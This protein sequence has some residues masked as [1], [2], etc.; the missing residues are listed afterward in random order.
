MYATPLST[1]RNDLSAV[2]SVGATLL[3]PTQIQ[4]MLGCA[5]GAFRL[6]GEL[7]YATGMRLE[8]LL[9]ARVRD[10]EAEGWCWV[11]RNERGEVVRRLRLPAR[12]R[13]AVQQHLNLLQ[14][15]HRHALAKGEGEVELG[16]EVAETGPG[17][18][19]R[20]CWQ[21]VFPSARLVPDA[22]SQRKVHTHLESL[23]V[24]GRLAE[25]GRAAGLSQPV[26]AQALRHAFAA[27]YL[28]NKRPL[29][30]LQRLLGHRTLDTTRRYVEVLQAALDRHPALARTSAPHPVA[31]SPSRRPSRDRVPVNLMLPLMA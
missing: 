7:L 19:R 13:E 26:H 22:R 14:Q 27:H 5:P 24:Q 29:E 3:Q 15:W 25:A 28:E 8:E 12:L 4:R 31:M 21:Y 20:W 1:G 23:E 10:V 11:V 9:Q 6:I 17:M 18:G 16:T 2:Q 30:D